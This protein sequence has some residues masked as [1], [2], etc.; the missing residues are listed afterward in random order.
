MCAFERLSAQCHAAR[1]LA[2]T[3]VLKL[4]LLLC[5]VFPAG[6]GNVTAPL[7]VPTSYADMPAYLS[8]LRNETVVPS[9]GLYVDMD[10]RKLNGKKFLGLNVPL[11]MK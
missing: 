4:F 6:H 5:S 2:Y 9:E 7:M 8:D 3:A 1:H 11:P 10:S